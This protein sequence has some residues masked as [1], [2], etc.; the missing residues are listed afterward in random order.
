MPPLYRVRNWDAL[1]ETSET[2]KLKHLAW[3]PIPNKHDGKGFRRLMQAGPLNYA[4]WVL[5]LQVASKCPQRGLLADQD[6][7]LT[8]SDLSIKTDLP[9]KTF[10]TALHHLLEIGWIETLNGEGLPITAGTSPATPADSPVGTELN[11]TERTEE[12]T[13]DSCSLQDFYKIYPRHD[14]GNVPEKSWTKL[15]RGER[16]ECLE[17]TPAWIKARPG[18]EKQFFPMPATFLNQ[19]RWRDPIEDL[20]Q[21]VGGASFGASSQAGSFGAA[22]KCYRCEKEMTSDDLIGSAKFC[23][24]CRKKGAL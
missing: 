17:K 13:K 10:E 16:L 4:A 5:I 11:R 8:P 20:T 7:P 19:K 1:F 15:S 21:K 6:G 18:T 12:N 24:D 9:V 22:R 2:R 14:G 3:V 23:R